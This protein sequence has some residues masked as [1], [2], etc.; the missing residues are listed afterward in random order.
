[1][2]YILFD[3]AT[4]MRNLNVPREDTRRDDRYATLPTPSV[5]PG[6]ILTTVETWL[7]TR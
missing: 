3:E 6:T 4:P 7:Y 1:M 5:L 2:D